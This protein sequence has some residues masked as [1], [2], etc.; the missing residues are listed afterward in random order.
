MS[1]LIFNGPNDELMLTE[2]TQPA[3]MLIGIVIIEILKKRNF[4]VNN[5][6]DIAAGHSLGEY[7]ALAA[8]ESLTLAETARLLKVRGKAMQESFPKNKGAMAA[9]LGLNFHEVE[10]AIL[11]KKSKYLC[12]IAN[13]NAPGQVVI[14]GE[15]ESVDQIIESLKSKGAKRAVKL[16]VS[17]PFHCDLMKPAK[18]IMSSELDNVEFSDPSIPLIQNVSV[19]STKDKEILKKNLVKQITKSVRWRETMDKFVELGVTDIIEVGA[20]NVLTNLS[21]RNAPNL[22]RFTLN[23][24]ESLEIF[25]RELDSV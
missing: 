15:I 13:D 18:E 4:L 11:E 10:E 23:S 24:K 22:Q 19:E 5:F 25:M 3:I 17:A 14:S 6:A 12:Q 7:T 1:D 21:K 16:P 2:N 8:L 9:I 20:G